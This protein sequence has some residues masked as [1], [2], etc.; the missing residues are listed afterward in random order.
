MLEVSQRRFGTKDKEEERESE[1]EEVA[2]PQPNPNTHPDQIIIVTDG[3]THG[4]RWR[5]FQAWE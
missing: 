1:R 2:I 5:S 4:N 3:T